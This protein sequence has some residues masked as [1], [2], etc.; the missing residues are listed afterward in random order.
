M[1]I[2]RPDIVLGAVLLLETK[3]DNTPPL[4]YGEADSQNT[5]CISRRH[6]IFD[7]EKCYKEK[8]SG[9]RS[10]RGEVLLTFLTGWPP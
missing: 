6:G 8:Q 9:K 5:R 2:Y 7:V 3:T 10:V 4:L 1:L